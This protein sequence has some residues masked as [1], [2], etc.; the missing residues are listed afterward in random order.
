M[1][2]EI[3][4]TDF[5]GLIK[6]ELNCCIESIGRSQAAFISTMDGHLLVSRDR[7]DSDIESLCPMSGSLIAISET[8]AE[9]LN[10]GELDDTIIRTTEG[11]LGIF[12]LKDSSSSL[13]LGIIS[14]RMVN[15]GQLVTQGRLCAEKIQSIIE[16]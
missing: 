16:S 5:L 14:L 9:V 13:M 6:S 15:L 2:Q 12:K 10:K 4:N 8:L 11:V 1:T 7:A 3:S